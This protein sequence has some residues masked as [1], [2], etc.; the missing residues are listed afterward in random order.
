MLDPAQV[1][2]APWRNGAG[3]T[4]ELALAT[5]PDGRMSWRISLASIDWDAPFSLFPEVDRLFVALGSL[6][7]TVDGVT[8]LMA[9]GDERRFAGESSVAVAVDEPTTALNVMTRRGWGRAEVA[10]RDAVEH[11]PDD[12]DVTIVL[13]GMVADV[14]L[15]ALAE[16]PDV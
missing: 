10:L 13:D 1:R 2:P 9:W 14:R 11:A 6:R 8:S 16:V 7:L 4:R 12:V 3:S 15:F 5:D